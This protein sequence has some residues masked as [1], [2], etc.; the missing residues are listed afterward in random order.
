MGRERT[1]EQ[2]LLTAGRL[3]EKASGKKFII[4]KSSSGTYRLSSGNGRVKYGKFMTA[5]EL[6]QIINAMAI[7]AG[8]PKSPA[9]N[10]DIVNISMAERGRKPRKNP[11]G[12]MRYRGKKYIPKLT[13]RKRTIDAIIVSSL[14]FRDR[15]PNEKLLDKA[16]Q[17]VPKSSKTVP[18]SA[19][20]AADPSNFEY[21]AFI[22]TFHGIKRIVLFD[23]NRVPRKYHADIKRAWQN[24]IGARVPKDQTIDGRIAHV[25]TVWDRYALR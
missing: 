23:R 6:K 15:T 14:F 4:E 25:D 10:Y 7:S 1:T 5:T 2:E 21:P 8:K 9:K 18:Y 22:K 17:Y 13:T 11:T 3:L 24:A 19:K 20:V 16:I 12:G